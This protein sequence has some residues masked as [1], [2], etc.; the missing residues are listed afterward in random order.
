MIAA[1]AGMGEFAIKHGGPPMATRIMGAKIVNSRYDYERHTFRLDYETTAPNS[2]P[3]MFNPSDDTTRVAQAL[4]RQATSEAP[5]QEELTPLASSSELPVVEDGASFA[6]SPA[7]IITPSA[8]SAVECELRCDV[9]TWASSLDVIVDPAPQTLTCLRRHKLA[10]SGGGLWLTIEHDATQVA[11]E[12]ITIV[13]RKGGAGSK[14]RGAVIVNGVKIRVDVEDLSEHEVQSLARK[15]RV[16]PAR[17]PLDQPPVLSVVRR[18]GTM[19]DD[20][21]MGPPLTNIAAPWYLGS[22]VWRLFTTAANQ[23]STS[24]PDKLTSAMSPAPSPDARPPM[25]FAFDALSRVRELHSQSI[26]DG[27]TLVSEKDVAV[28]RKIDARLSSKIPIHKAQ[29]VIEGF[30]A[31][32][33]AAVISNS[34][35]RIQ[36][37]DRIES[38]VP[39]DTYGASCTTLFIVAKSGFPFRDRGFFAASL[40]ARISSDELQE[41]VGSSDGRQ[42]ALSITSGSVRGRLPMPK[43]H[44][45]ALICVT[46][47]FATITPRRYSQH[48]VNPLNL[49]IGQ[50]LVEGWILETLDPYTSENLAIPSTRCTL[51]SAIDLAGSAPLSYNQSHNL[52]NVRGILALE[53]YLKGR[54][55]PPYPLLPAP[56]LNIDEADDDLSRA[57]GQLFSWKISQTDLTRKLLSASFVP[58]DKTYQLVVLLK[59][60][61]SS[62]DSTIGEAYSRAATPNGLPTSSIPSPSRPSTPKNRDGSPTRTSHFRSPSRSSTPLQTNVSSRSRTISLSFPSTF[63]SSVHAG[64]PEETPSDLVVCELV[65]DQSMYKSGCDLQVRS[66][67]LTLSAEDDPSSPIPLHSTPITESD[68]VV[69]FALHSLSSSTLASASFSSPMKRCV[70]RIMVPTVAYSTPPVHDPLSGEIPTPLSKPGWLTS[71]E[72][73]GAIVEVQIKPKGERKFV[74]MVGDTRIPF[75]STSTQ[76]LSE[77]ERVREWPRLRR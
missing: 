44:T 75:T 11:N 30:G 41:H 73:K 2:T 45:P 17:V 25:H 8:P 66:R 42:R 32:E 35:S 61:V 28:Y 40:V 6:S 62:A 54:P 29:R 69:H 16:K 55:P 5:S 48:K 76:S 39:L 67:L 19:D 20:E 24:P 34:P 22:P 72:E 71:L 50:I 31:E 58:E 47:S 43:S 10:N 13:I 70:L 65:I 3:T 56:A 52:A 63:D 37:D 74:V 15:K 64:L 49:P 59:P 7:D 33:I 18:R 4:E 51:V 14:D 57:E 27:W 23:M 38:L 1:V 12:R 77:S 21:Q 46:A 26:S 36:W 9:D 60:Q 68:I 53:R